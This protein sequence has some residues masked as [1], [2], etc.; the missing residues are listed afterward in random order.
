MINSSIILEIMFTLILPDE[1][2]VD[3]LRCAEEQFNRERL[4]I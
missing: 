1:V 4:Y 2:E 3:I